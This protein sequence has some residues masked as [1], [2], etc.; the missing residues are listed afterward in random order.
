MALPCSSHPKLDEVERRLDAT[1]MRE[2]KVHFH[3]SSFA[4]CAISHHA[5]I[6]HLLSYKGVQRHR[7][8]HAV[9]E[10]MEA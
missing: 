10:T 6:C 5:P 3:I 8:Q 4:S 2:I 1:T 9:D 7:L